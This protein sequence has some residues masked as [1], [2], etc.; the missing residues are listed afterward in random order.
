MNKEYLPS[1][2][3]NMCECGEVHPEHIREVIASAP[4]GEMLYGLSD[5]FKIF[6]D[7]TRLSILFALREG[8]MCGCDLVLLLGMTKAVV[9]YQLKVL[10][11]HKLVKSE[12]DGRRVF[13]SLNDDHV[14]DIIDLAVEH[15]SE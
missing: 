12:K 3:D 1:E 6:G 9:S 4:C 10:S 11:R 5:F 14:R 15:I 8:A 2:P 13:Y 7:S